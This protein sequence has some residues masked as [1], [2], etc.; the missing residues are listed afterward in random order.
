[1][2]RAVVTGGAGFIGSNLAHRLLAAGHHVTVFDN[3]SRSGSQANLDWLRT[4][5]SAVH[6]RA[7][8][9]DVRDF[10]ALGDAL[11]GAD[12]VYHLA[13]QVAVT[14]SVRD[15]RADFE[16]N[17]VGTFNLLEALRGLPQ[18]PVLIYSSTNKVYGDLGSIELVEEPTRYRFADLPFGVSENQ[19]LDFHSPYG[20]SKGAA[21]QYVRDYCRVYG[22]R[23]VVMR[24]S[25]IYGTRQF[26]IEDQGW[27]AWLATAALRGLPITIFGDGKQVRDLL[28]I[29]DLLDVYEAAVDRIDRVQGEIYNIGGGPANTL[30][31]W[32]ELGPVLERHA[33]RSIAV[34]HDLWRVGDQRVFVSDIRK[35]ERE[36]GW[37]PR[38]GVE[39]GIRSLIEWIRENDALGA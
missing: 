37:R 5:R 16:A 13:G 9:G 27:V 7:I 12:R 33:G 28:F 29:D 34:S 39:E 30:S 15:P 21:D 19:A 1:M 35:A 6:L 17:A 4:T 24:Q 23:A 22:L 8:V 26:G 14:D 36:L 10:E 31:V 32:Q 38:I 3:L 25:C 11:E 18:R 20:C 2:A